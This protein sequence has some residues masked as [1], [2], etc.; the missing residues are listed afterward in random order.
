MKMSWDG[1]LTAILVACALTTTAVLLHK[2]FFAS[3]D[4]GISDRPVFIKDWRAHLEKGQ[5]VGSPDAPVQLIE[6]FDYECPHCATFHVTLENL[7]RIY[8]QQTAISFVH[9]PLPGHDYAEPA[10]RAAECAGEQGFFESMHSV[11]F[12]KQRALG[13]GAWRDFAQQ[14]GVRDLQLF[15]SCIDTDQPRHRI[16]EGKRLGEQLGVRGTPTLIINGWKFSRPPSAE[17]LDHMIKLA[18]AGK[19]PAFN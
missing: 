12:D 8:P 13:S 10:A 18:L 15:V 9:Y 14:A 7:R 4:I 3:R 5:R 19:K 6:F 17:E 16:K 11:L 2:E 1:A